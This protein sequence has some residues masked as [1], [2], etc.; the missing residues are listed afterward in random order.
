MRRNL[1]KRR[2]KTPGKG[3]GNDVIEAKREE[4]SGEGEN[5]SFQELRA[6]IA[7]GFGRGLVTGVLRKFELIWIS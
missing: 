4:V 7:I 6:H 3:Q 5:N 2:S 1:I